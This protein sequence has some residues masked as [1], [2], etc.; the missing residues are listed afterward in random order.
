MRRTASRACAGLERSKERMPGASARPILMTRPRLLSR[1][2]SGPARNPPAPV[3]RIRRMSDVVEPG[4][5]VGEV[6]AHVLGGPR[7]ALLERDAR[8]PAGELEGFLVAADEPHHLAALGADARP[9]L[10]DLGAAAGDLHEQARG[11]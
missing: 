10:L 4:L 2:A 7:E 9:V 3:I 11:L 8:L 5:V 1:S 6:R